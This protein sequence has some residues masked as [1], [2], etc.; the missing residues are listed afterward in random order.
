MKLRASDYEVR[1]IS[2]L[3]FKTAKAFVAKHHY[4]KG[5]SHTAVHAHGLYRRGSYELLGVALWLPPTKPA[6]MSVNQIH[7]RRVLSLSRLCVHPDVPSNAATFLMGR[8]IRLI[9]QEG[10]WISL[11]TYADE[12]REHTGAIYRATN[13]TYVGKMKGAARWED[14]NGK[15]V[16]VLATKSRTVAQM[17]AFGYRKIGTFDKHKFVMH[18]RIQK[19]PIICEPDSLLWW[20]VAGV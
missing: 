17:Q 11:V 5:C 3:D 9:R 8:S 15:Q 1:V 7:W 14:E 12:F 10:K 6:A 13:W 20:A 4:S 19:R 2:P 16:S 18:L